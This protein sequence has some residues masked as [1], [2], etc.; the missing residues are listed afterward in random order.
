MFDYQWGNPETEAACQTRMEEVVRRVYS[1]DSSVL[2]LSHGGP[3]SGLY[4]KL[5]G[6]D[7]RI[8]TGYTGLYAYQPGSDG[9]SYWKALIAGDHAHLGDG[10]SMGVNDQKEQGLD[11]SVFPPS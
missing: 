11:P 9:D 6:S 1:A 2:L 8:P 4:R 5:T 10:T 3:T 7:E